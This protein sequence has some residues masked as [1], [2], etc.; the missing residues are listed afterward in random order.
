MHYNGR[1]G[2]ICRSMEGDFWNWCYTETHLP[3][4]SFTLAKG[5]FRDQTIPIASPVEL[6]DVLGQLDAICDRLDMNQDL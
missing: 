3:I 6:Q 5:V 1:T 4:Q 2:C